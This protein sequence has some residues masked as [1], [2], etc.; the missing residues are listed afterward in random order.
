MAA[1]QADPNLQWYVEFV[2]WKDEIER[3]FTMNNQALHAEHSER[4]A[5]QREQEYQRLQNLGDVKALVQY[6]GKNAE[7]AM[8]EAEAARVGMSDH[9]GNHKAS[10]RELP[11][12]MQALRQVE[13]LGDDLSKHIESQRLN[14]KRQMESAL[15]L[16]QER[17]KGRTQTRVQI[18][19][20]IGAIV[21][22]LIAVLG[23]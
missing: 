5:W 16:L 21:T 4:E 6:A 2:H 14:D 13:K 8:R 12:V 9:L 3:Q 19:V 20:T 11:Q 18:I 22:A 17:E 23:K 15:A 10:D 7:Q 1:Q